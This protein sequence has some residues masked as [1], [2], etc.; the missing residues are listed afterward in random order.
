MST[1][2]EVRT[3]VRR[4][5][6]PG[7]PRRAPLTAIAVGAAGGLLGAWVMVRCNALI[8]ATEDDGHDGRQQSTERFRAAASP[9]DTDGTV[10]HEPA[11]RQAASR[12]AE[13]VTGEPLGERGRRIGAPLVHYGFG[14][15]AGA[16]YGALVEMQPSAAA[17]WGLSYGTA[18]WLT[19]D[20]IGVPL[21]GLA[22]PP[23]EYPFVRHATALA[24]HLAFG[25]TLETVRR[26]LLG[27]AFEG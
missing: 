26:L 8:G 6:R 5:E 21:A 3:T 13:A 9:N 25:A 14:V 20:E 16:F 24:T 1:K 7:R 2:A 23:A 19:A 18:V 4:E 10:A 11:T 17:G 22:G 27:R 12:V 15:A